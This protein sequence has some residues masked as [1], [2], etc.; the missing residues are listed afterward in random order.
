MQDELLAL[1][2]KAL[3]DSLGLVKFG[4]EVIT[5]NKSFVEEKGVLQK[6][7]TNEQA[8]RKVVEEEMVKLNGSVSAS[9]ELTAKLAESYKTFRAARVEVPSLKEQVARADTDMAESEKVVAEVCQ[10]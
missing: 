9:D 3:T 5:K 1:P 10:E 2:M 7:V 6:N 8:A 4:R